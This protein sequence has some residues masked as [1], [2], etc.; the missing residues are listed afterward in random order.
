MNSLLR[1][2]RF[3]EPE[4]TLELIPQP[5]DARHES[6]LR[7]QMLLSPVNASDLIPITGAY[8]HRIQPPLVAGYEGV[9]IVTQAPASFAHLT[10]TRVLP[11]RGHGT[12]QQ[13]VDCPAELA[14]PVPEDIS[15]A[16]AARA[17]INPLAATLMLKHFPPEGKRVLVTA[18][19]SECAQLLGQWALKFGAREVIGVYRSATHAK[20]LAAMGIIPV[21]QRDH[22]AIA[23]YAQNAGV[24][25]EAVGGELADTLLTHL[26][27]SA[28]FVSYGLLS[29]T[30]FSMQKRAATLHWF[31]VRHYL[32]AM[33]TATWQAEFKQIW[34]LLRQ[35]PT[36]D[37][38]L[39]PLAQWQ[40]AIAHYRTAGRTRKTMLLFDV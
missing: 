1:Y 26:P 29:A 25:Y 36:G 21:A 6:H 27:D 19:G 35:T 34:S 16:L 9:G 11:L 7:V 20:K 22:E 38:T 5:L 31:H 3:G 2:T 24:V 33:D 32:A 12:W 28:H 14:V 13:F 30:P 8:G 10:G 37:V 15:D 18:A 39:F 23:H 17:Y 40:A 4:T